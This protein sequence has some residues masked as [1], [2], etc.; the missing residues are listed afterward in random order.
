M[1]PLH[2][3]SWFRP[4]MLAPVLASATLMATAAPTAFYVRERWDLVQGARARARRVAGALRAE[5]GERPLLW[6]YDAPKLGERLGAE[7]LDRGALCVLDG[8]G[9]PVEVPGG[10]APAR[11]LWG[12]V[13]LRVDGRLEATVWAAEDQGPLLDDTA[14][15]AGLSALL[16]ALLGAVLYL[17]PVRAIALAERR[18][19]LLLGRL[20]L[21]LQE[22]DRRRIARDLH[23]GAGQA[24]T[25]AR[26]ELLA[27]R[28]KGLDPEAAGRIARHLD[29]ALAEVRRSTTALAPPALAELGLTGALGRH[30]ETFGD[31]AGIEV[32]CRVAED[33]P[34]LDAEV[35]TAC[36]RIAQEALTNTARH[37]GATR[38]WVHLSARAGQLHLEIGDDGAGLDE[39]RAGGGSG[40]RGIRERAQLL[41]GTVVVE[42]GGRGLRI[43]VALPITEE[44][45]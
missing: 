28:A 13:E 31:A 35:E 15:L 17:L 18:I 44:P 39:E 33:L 27:L 32:E 8:R 7:G 24:I 20:A 29:E 37:A 22:E 23:D 34:P 3:T 6:R 14:L 16:A 10:A 40:M 4:R 5:I 43:A 45:A 12:R 9:V 38:A 41:G 21:T 2:L 36:Y 26:L 42:N 19:S 25:A 11:P 1:T 30:C